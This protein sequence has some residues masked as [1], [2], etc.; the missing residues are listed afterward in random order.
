[1]LDTDAQ[2]P[3]GHP[4]L[5]AGQQ[6][7]L[8][9]VQCRGS[10]DALASMTKTEWGDWLRT[11]S[12]MADR[13]SLASSARRQWKQLTQDALNRRQSDADQALTG[14]AAP[15]SPDGAARGA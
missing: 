7:L 5:S 9:R 13:P 15:R 3:A 11:C 6:E 12:Y 1:M 2:R 14:P 10:R 8:H 4:A